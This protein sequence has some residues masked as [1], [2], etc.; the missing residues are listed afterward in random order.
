MAK[1]SLSHQ[2]HYDFGLRAMKSVLTNAG[3]LIRSHEINREGDI[4]VQ[5]S[6]LVIS[7]IVNALFPKLLSSDLAKLQRLIEDIFPGI[8]PEDMAQAD[9]IKLIKE[10]AENFGWIASEIWINKIIQLYYI[11]QISH[12]FMLVGPSA[13]GKTSSRTILLNV[14]SK[15]DKQESESYVINPKSVTKDTLFG[16][17][18]PVTR[19]WTDGVFTRILRTIVDNQRGEMSKRHWI[20][21]D[22]DVDPED[23]RRRRP[24][25]RNVFDRL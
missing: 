25:F 24:A 1:E 15:I 5:E 3:Q 7:S 4:L 2:T 23:N 11:Q 6:R 8:K 13:T 14:L 16:A 19:E 21:F 22:G 10:E 20:V 17:L 12:G 18:D 9:L